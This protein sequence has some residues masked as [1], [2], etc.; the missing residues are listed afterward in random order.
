MLSNNKKLFQTGLG[1]L[2]LTKEFGCSRTSKEVLSIFCEILEKYHNSLAFIDSATVY[3]TFQNTYIDNIIDCAL[4][5]LKLSKPPKINLKVGTDL[6]FGN[7]EVIFK[8][9]MLTLEKY[10]KVTDVEIMIHKPTSSNLNLNQRLNNLLTSEGFE[11]S[12]LST[13]SLKTLEIYYESFKLRN[14]QLALNPIDYIANKSLL[15]FAIKSQLK[16]TAR[17]VLASGLLTANKWEIEHPFL[18]PMRSK[19]WDT[20]TSKRILQQRLSARDRIYLFWLNNINKVKFEDFII[21]AVGNLNEVHYLLVGGSSMQQL[22]S[23]LKLENLT[24]I[25]NVSR[26]WS[27]K[28]NWQAPY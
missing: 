11:I 26:F 22:N 13:N 16:V 14:L 9:L 2:G 12:G 17:S 18:D 15:S 23:N 1:T 19:F 4:K 10:A 3:K 24:Y 7:F 27:L 6:T 5:N 21:S 8:R 20:K 28:E 25:N